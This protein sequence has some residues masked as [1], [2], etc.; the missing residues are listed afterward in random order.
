[1]AKH[2]PLHLLG[3]ILFW[4]YHRG[5]W[6]YDVLCGLILVFI[7]ATPRGVFEGTYFD[8]GESERPTAE[9]SAPAPEIV[10]AE[11]AAAPH[12]PA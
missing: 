4:R 5:G 6:Q 11:S 2:G 1:M 12:D 7:F 3:R 10:D 9:V 8:R